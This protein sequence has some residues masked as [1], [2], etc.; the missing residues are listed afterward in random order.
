MSKQMYLPGKGFSEYPFAWLSAYGCKVLMSLL[1]VA[2][3][4][5][6]GAGAAMAADVEI[7]VRPG[8]AGLYR[9]DQ[10]VQLQAS[11]NNLTSEEF[12]GT[13]VV[14][15]RPGPGNP[16]ER[17]RVPA[18]KVKVVVKP[19]SNEGINIRVPGE[20][21]EGSAGSV[22]ATLLREGKEVAKSSV[23]G[24]NVG[25]G[26][27]CF[28]LSE[29]A[30]RSDLFT[31][32]SKNMGNQFIVKYIDITELPA[33][34]LS[35]GVA[36]Y[37]VVA[38]ENLAA[39]GQKQVVA[40]KDW[41][42][43]GGT[44]LLSG[45]AGSGEGG[46]FSDIS[47][48]LSGS[49]LTVRGSLGGLREGG[50]YI[51]ALMGRAGE[52]TV[53]AE[54]NGVPLMA[55]RNLGRGQVL[56]SAFSIEELAGDNSKVWR[57][58]G[59]APMAGGAIDK[60]RM[61]NRYMIRDMLLNS[62]SYLPMLKIPSTP[63]LYVL[64]VLYL[65]LVGPLIYLVLKR[66]DKRDWMWGAVPLVA[67]VAALGFY[68]LSPA[69]RLQ[70]YLVQTATAIDILEPGL[71]E[72]YT[73]S[74]VVMPRGG[75]LE[76]EGPRGMLVEP[77]RY[78]NTPGRGIEVNFDGPITRVSYPGVE[79]GSLRQVSAY[80]LLWGSGGIEGSL[81]FSAGE[82]KGILVNKTALD[83]KDCKLLLGWH[84]IE[85]GDLK[86]GSSQNIN[87]SLDKWQIISDPEKMIRESYAQ[88]QDGQAQSPMVREMTS[89][90]LMAGQPGSLYFLGWSQAAPP[91]LFS[92]L[93]PS[94]G[95]QE[96]ALTLVRQRMDITFPQGKFK[97]P[98][99]FVQGQVIE[100]ATEVVPGGIMVH[101]ENVV[102][103]YDIKSVLG[104]KKFKI[105]S[106]EIAPGRD[107][108]IR[109]KQANSD[110]WVS[111]DGG[112]Y[113][114]TGDKLGQFLTSRG[115]ITLNLSKKITSS[116]KYLPPSPYQGIAVEGEVLK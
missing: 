77:M 107:L 41:V 60:K 6:Q 42:R 90:N 79:F 30:S 82:V 111:L 75:D 84:M 50:G 33:D 10:P 94:T 113:M 15:Q 76:V 68:L 56:Y 13:L 106:I 59:L 114:L 115:T 109:V 71:A 24:T 110:E 47:P 74:T 45:G 2:L 53:T 98:A 81:E 63:L 29:K 9:M 35:L 108:E 88:G 22:E 72:V 65:L 80:G 34:P 61:E 99:G 25:G 44:L 3:L 49:P 70:G 23:E 43:L 83:L 102:V 66:T 73:S 86:A 91:D 36:D 101:S 55:E 8:I 19:G 14:Q 54:E 58:M 97:L 104:D 78:S 52:G 62:G 32:M 12:A 28:V 69:N 89:R 40:V 26:L 87:E 95:G 85:L 31:W 57:A 37:L 18:Y 11:I 116:E 103:A 5:L 20:L 17:F 7:K 46:V 1:V 92:I 39:L 67:V 112:D 93:K 100:G 96:S 64:W 105:N 48:V 16:Q 21:L 4:F 27:V 51:A 38:P